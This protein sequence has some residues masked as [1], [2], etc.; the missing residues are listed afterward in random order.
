MNVLLRLFNLTSA[1]VAVLTA[2]LLVLELVFQFA[3][4]NIPFYLNIHYLFFLYFQID[5]VFRIAH[6]S[7]RHFLIK[8]PTDF[9]AFLPYIHFFTEISQSTLFFWTQM[10]LL[11]LFAGRIS[12]TRFFFKSESLKPPHI[13]LFFFVAI[14][15]IGSLVLGLP[16][17][18]NGPVI[19]YIDA[20]FMS[21]SAVCVT[22]LVT[23]PVLDTFSLFGQIVLLIIIQ[24]GGLG[25]LGFSAILALFLTQRVSASDRQ[26]IQENYATMNS[27]ELIRAIYSIFVYTLV[28]EGIGTLCFMVMWYPHYDSLGSLFYHSLFHSISSFCNAGFSLFSNSF[29]LFYHSPGTLIVSGILII[30]GGLGFPAIFNLRNRFINRD[31]H[32]QLKLQTRIILITTGALIAFGAF[33]FIVFEFGN[34]LGYGTLMDRILNG[35]YLSVSARTAG[36]TSFDLNAL[37]TG[38]ILLLCVLMFIG[39]SPGSTGGGIKTTTFGILMATVVQT[40]RGKGSIFVSNRKIP[41]YNI[42]N[43][44]TI[45]FLSI[46]VVLIFFIILS[47]IESI[48]LLPLFFETISAFGTV[49]LSLGITSDLS[50]AGKLF[51]IILMFVGR[52]GALTFAFALTQKKKP[53]KYALPEERVLIV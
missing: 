1:I 25:I 12:H 18:L 41:E 38:S 14:A 50:S 39:A 6:K 22:G 16:V 11:L 4:D 10:G 51:I 24:I 23:Q 32:F 48:P 44:F 21:T 29:E 17:S 26:M 31:S 47:T 28:F 3:A 2:T 42:F 20:L 33:C 45:F 43:A 46:G 15:F 36:F 19:P 37:S 13:L 8:H 34:A 9:V 49:G 30:I 27:S 5:L 40:I 7:R 53:Y 52:V 35:L